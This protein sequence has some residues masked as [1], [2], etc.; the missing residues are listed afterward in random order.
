[1]S[2]CRTLC[3]WLGSKLRPRPVE[4]AFY[5]IHVTDPHRRFRLWTYVDWSSPNITQAVWE[6]LFDVLLERHMW[7][8]LGT[9]A[10]ARR[11]PLSST[12]LEL[13]VFSQYAIDERKGQLAVAVYMPHAYGLRLVQTIGPV[14]ID[15][16]MSDLIRH[17]PPERM[18]HV[19]PL[20]CYLLGEW[21]RLVVSHGETVLYQMSAISAKDLSVWPIA[22]ARAW[23]RPTLQF[24]HC[25]T[26]AQD[27]P[28]G[29]WMFETTLAIAEQRLDWDFNCRQLWQLARVRTRL[30]FEPTAWMVRRL[31][32]RIPLQPWIYEPCPLHQSCFF[33]MSAREQTLMR[34]V[35]DRRLDTYYACI[36]RQL[37]KKVSSRDIIAHVMRF[38]YTSHVITRDHAFHCLCQAHRSKL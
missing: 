26:Y 27:T 23:L 14:W 35:R 25:I 16:L 10:F 19:Q 9:H 13:L 34:M 15:F 2:F 21:K 20:L 32:A 6:Q 8:E 28:T 1:M 7:F 11:S 36:F 30:C 22:V 12:P 3:D 24:H 18:V 4:D 38:V 33:S 37:E 5:A 17:T 29:R 31:V